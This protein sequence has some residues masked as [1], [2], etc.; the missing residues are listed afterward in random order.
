VDKVYSKLA[1]ID[2]DDSG[3]FGQFREKEKAKALVKQLQDMYAST[4]NAQVWDQLHL[5]ADSLREIYNIRDI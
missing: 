2:K 5:L 4:K 1:I 3:I